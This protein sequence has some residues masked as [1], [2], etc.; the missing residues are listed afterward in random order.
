VGAMQPWLTL[1]GDR[2]V[3][4]YTRDL[5]LYV[6]TVDLLPEAAELP[7]RP[8]EVERLPVG[9]VCGGGAAWVFAPMMF[10]GRRVTARARAG[11]ATPR[12]R[13]HKRAGSPTSS[14]T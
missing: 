9:E 11:R 4:A 12:R 3:V 7:M 8:A 13:G 14:A 1:D 2:L 10:L 5:G 6:A